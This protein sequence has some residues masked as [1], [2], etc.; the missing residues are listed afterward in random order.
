MH[1]SSKRCPI[2]SASQTTLQRAVVEDTFNDKEIKETSMEAA[3]ADDKVQKLKGLDIPTLHA[4][5]LKHMVQQTSAQNKGPAGG[6]KSQAR[7]GA[8]HFKQQSQ[9]NNAW[10]G[11][12]GRGYG[13]GRCGGRGG[14]GFF[15]GKG[16]GAAGS[17][18]RGGDPAP[19][20]QS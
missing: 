13:R 2:S 5:L 9:F 8:P 12:G 7:G 14:R 20:S 1:R 17:K 16:R 10:S 4:D 19:G 15:S 6:K 11:Q 18:G 3:M